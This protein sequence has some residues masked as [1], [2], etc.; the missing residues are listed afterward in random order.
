MKY[1]ILFTLLF[2]SSYSWAKS[3]L[4]LSEFVQLSKAHDPQYKSI[5]AD[6]D[7][8]KFIIDNGMPTSEFLFSVSNEHGRNYF[9]DTSTSLL[10]TSLTKDILTTGTSLSLS[11]TKSVQPAQLS[12]A[13][14]FRLEQSLYN[15]I[16]G[17]D[18][19]LL[20]TSL[21][22]E[23]T[24]LELQIKE[25]YENYLVTI[26]SKYL[27]FQ[28][29]FLDYEFSE[30]NLKDAKKLNDIVKKKRRSN[31]A[32]STDLD[33]SELSVLLRHEELINKRKEFEILKEEIRNFIGE[34]NLFE[35]PKIKSKNLTLVEANHFREI[36]D[37]KNLRANKIARLNEQISGFNQNIV[38]NENDIRVNFIA[39][40][41]KENSERFTSTVKKDEA[42]VGL[43]VEIPL[44]DDNAKAKAGISVVEAYKAKLTRNN[45]HAETIRN[46][47]SLKAEL[48]ELKLK[49]SVNKRKVELTKRILKDEQGRYEYGKI[50]LEKLLEVKNDY[51]AYSFQYQSDIVEHSKVYIK[52][53]ALNDQLIEFTEAL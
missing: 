53:L 18:S 8:V 17:A 31:I 35:I 47:K 24:V 10:T 26:I 44:G 46:L 1:L 40:Y 12:D 33:K 14:N 48:E 28:K 34:D 29:A 20:K 21:E 22:K 41:N 2:N 19:R 23:T 32:T 39:A 16:F 11:H 9:N 13:T 7:K 38:S 37:I 4:S 25:N 42:V 5:F 27:D 30:F 43:K 50:E 6:Q 36:Q 45:I 52:W 3:K 51:A 49:V 15:N